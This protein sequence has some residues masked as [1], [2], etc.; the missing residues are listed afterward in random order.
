MCE[1]EDNKI[2]E[3]CVAELVFDGNFDTYMDED[4]VS[5]AIEEAFDSFEEEFSE[6]D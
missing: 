3:E 5:A 1:C 2:C 4:D 6:L